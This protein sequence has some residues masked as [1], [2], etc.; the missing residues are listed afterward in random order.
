LRQHHRELAAV[1]IEPL[2]Q[3]AAGMIVHPPGLL[4]GLRE[5]TQAHDVLLIADEIAVGCGRSGA[6]FACQQEDVVPDFLCLG[7]GL[8]GG[9]LPIA[10][11]VT[12]GEIYRAF[13]GRFDQGRTLHHGHTFSGNPLGAAAALASLDVFDEEGTLDNLPPKIARLGEHLCRL[14]EH[15]HVTAT[16]QRGLMA[17]FELTPD[18]SAGLPYPASERRAWRVCREALARGV[19]IRPLADVLYV[20]PPLAISAEEL[21]LLMDTIVAAVDKVTFEKQ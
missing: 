6:M 15:P 20:M 3:C 11:T 21:E 7:K 5:L 10:A 18:K 14:A 12:H 2:V 13:L 4:R 19:W 8:S 17:A 1:V 16:R 9:Y